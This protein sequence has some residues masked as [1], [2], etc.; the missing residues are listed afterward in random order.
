MKKLSAFVTGTPAT[1]GV[2]MKLVMFWPIGSICD[3]GTTFPVNGS[4]MKPSPSGF[5][6]VVNGS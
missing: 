1:F 5:G 4:R 6:L 3:V 2:G